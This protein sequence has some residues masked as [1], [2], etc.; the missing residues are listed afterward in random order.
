LL[1]RNPAISQ[2][3]QEHELDIVIPVY[4]EGPNILRTL[5][6][7]FRS[8]KTAFRVF[9]VYDKEDDDTIPVIKNI[10]HEYKNRIVLVKNKGRGPHSAVCTGFEKST[11]PAVIMYPADDDYNDGL[12]D[13]LFKKWKEEGCEI[14][15]AS[16]FIKDGCMKGAPLLKNVLIRIA[17]F[18]LCHVGR[19][20]THDPSN[21][22][23][24]FSR[25][26]LNEFEIES[27]QG[28]TYSIE[29]LMKTHRKGWKIGEVPAKWHERKEGQSRFKVLKWLPAYLRWFFYGMTA[30]WLRGIK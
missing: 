22:L 27:S 17:A 8:N 30:G 3:S 21:G 10:T 4:N 25:R 23:R 18:T 2:P 24:L 16:R 9:I 29:L 15:C 20:S 6:W 1:N 26:V 13:R 7:L 12:I 14:V 19:I 28:F 5:D 11:S